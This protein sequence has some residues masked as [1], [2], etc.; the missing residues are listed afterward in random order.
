MNLLDLYEEM[1]QT[2][3]G[4]QTSAF[5]A[6]FLRALKKVIHDLNMRLGEEIKTPEYIESQDIGFP[7]YCDNVFH[8]GIKFY[9][10]RAG[11]WA[12]DP[13]T[14]SRQFYEIELRKVI[15]HAI[16]QDDDFVTRNGE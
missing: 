8:P 9:M 3:G 16:Y 14:E 7:E 13:D 2:M 10:Q 4:G 6:G 15:G 1:G 12:Q 11:G 5:E